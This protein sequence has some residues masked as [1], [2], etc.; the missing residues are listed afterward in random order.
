MLIQISRNYS[1]GTEN[2]YNIPSVVEAK[3]DSS[4]DEALAEAELVIEVVV[5]ELGLSFLKLATKHVSKANG[6]LT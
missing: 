2:R 3:T 6:Q 5:L 1:V 4:V